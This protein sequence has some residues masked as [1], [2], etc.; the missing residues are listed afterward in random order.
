MVLQT[1]SRAIGIR[2]PRA[3]GSGAFESRVLPVTRSI[4]ERPDR[5]SVAVAARY[6]VFGDRVLE[7]GPQLGL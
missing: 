3:A 6:S 5:S 1:R 7:K 2:W 4:G